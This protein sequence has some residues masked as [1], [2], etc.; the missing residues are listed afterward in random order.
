M[1]VPNT[2][3]VVDPAF[4]VPAHRRYN[5]TAVYASPDANREHGLVQWIERGGGRVGPVE[6]CCSE[7]EGWF[8]KAMSDIRTDTE[9]I[10][11]PGWPF[12]SAKCCSTALCFQLPVN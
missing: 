12:T 7:Q 6:I 9:L 2:R 4:A 11:L 5:R 3:R 10:T 8:L 1:S